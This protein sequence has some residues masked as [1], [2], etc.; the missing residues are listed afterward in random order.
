MA[1]RTEDHRGYSIG[2]TLAA[3]ERPW[4]I[5]W[6]SH[7]DEACPHDWELVLLAADGR[8]RVH[9]EECVR[10]ELCHVPRCGHSTDEDPCDLRR[11]HSGDHL[12]RSEAWKVPPFEED[13]IAIR[14]G[15][16][17]WQKRQAE[18]AAVPVLPE[19]PQDG[20]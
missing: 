4:P 5:G 11:H 6:E 2:P 12:P 1:A 14:F 16:T 7:V 13:P 8:R 19:A 15:W 9:V 17:R 3:D 18:R 20:K 10:C